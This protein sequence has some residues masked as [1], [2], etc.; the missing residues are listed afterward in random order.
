MTFDKQFGRVAPHGLAPVHLAEFLGAQVLL[1]TPLMAAYA[2]GGAR[3]A[4]RERSQPDAVQLMLP[5]ATAAPFALYLLFHSLH[6]RV[7]G[8]WPVPLFGAFA[9]CAA[10]AAER[11]GGTKIARVARR[12]TP[13]VGFVTCAA[14]FLLIALPSPSPLGRLDPTL[15]LRGWPR[16]AAD[17]EQ[18]RVRTG[19][20]WVGTESYGVYA[21]LNAEGGIA[22]P[23]LDV[24]ERER[25]WPDA[26]HKPDFTRPGLVV[27]LARRMGP[28]ELPRCFTHVEP[29]GDLT[30]AGGL[31]RNQR[32]AAFL[33]S[34]PRRDVWTLGC[35]D[36]ISP[37]VWR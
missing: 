17:I 10:V 9:I 27:D 23:L 32:Y 12:L 14:A 31:G 5:L 33:V 21:Q 34:G 28:A 18:L 25:Y 16:F 11:S 15:A 37:G 24:V 3:R 19:A 36:E 4:W 8:H 1:F 26:P 22:A 20:A 2:I 35:P 30:R 29:A 13:V 6:D 7:Q